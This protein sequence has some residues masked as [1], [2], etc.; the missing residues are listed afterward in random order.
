MGDTDKAKTILEALG[1]EGVT[2]LE[3]LGERR[4]VAANTVLYEPGD[5]LSG[6]DIVV[7]GA[8]EVAI[9]PDDGIEHVVGTLRD[10]AI[11]GVLQSGTQGGAAGRARAVE[12]CDLL[13]IPHGA[14]L[15]V[16]QEKPH[17]TMAVMTAVVDQMRAQAQ[18][19]IADLMNV[20][21]WNADITGI[22]QLSFGDLITS[23]NGVTLHLADGRA[24]SGRVLR[25]DPE[26]HGGYVAIKCGDG[27]LH[28]VRSE[29]IVSIETDARGC[30][31]EKE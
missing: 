17:L 10:G 26:Q 19:A 31:E 6:F 27:K 5:E 30:R 18:I 20:V 22:S 13:T 2:A 14:L 12:S 7:H 29:A 24:V 21:R 11:L 28:I 15:Q 25:I 1:D 16:L 3:K 23:T 4:H 8:I 9:V